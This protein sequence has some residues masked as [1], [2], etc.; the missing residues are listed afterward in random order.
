MT[1][2]SDTNQTK[3]Q[4]AVQPQMKCSADLIKLTTFIPKL[5]IRA[6]DRAGELILVKP[7]ETELIQEIPYL[8]ELVIESAIYSN[9]DEQGF[10]YLD[11]GSDL[12]PYSGFVG[13]YFRVRDCLPLLLDDWPITICTLDGMKIKQML[14]L[15]EEIRDPKLKDFA[16]VFGNLFVYVKMPDFHK[17]G[18]RYLQLIGSSMKIEEL[19]DFLAS[20]QLKTDLDY[21]TYKPLL[22]EIESHVTDLDKL[23]VFLSKI[24]YRVKKITFHSEYEL[25]DLKMRPVAHLLSNKAQTWEVVTE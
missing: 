3:R 18:R 23:L 17:V 12:V 1:A 19:V 5:K 16:R 21:L 25:S 22:E 24:S 7:L 6:R 11:L 10:A 4:V 14:Q 2:T 15:A 13:F 8:E 9:L 20:P